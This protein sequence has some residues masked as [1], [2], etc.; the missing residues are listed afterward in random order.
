MRLYTPEGWF[1][2][3]SVVNEGYPFTFV[4]G[5]RATGKTFGALKKE[6]IDSEPGHRFMLIRR[7]Q[8]Q[9]DIINKPEFSPFKPV[10]SLLG[11]TTVTKTISKYNG[12]FYDGELQDDGT[13]VPIGEPLGFSAALSTF[14]NMRSFAADEIVRMIYDEFIPQPQERPIRDEANALYNAIESVN[15]NRELSGR[16]PVQLVGLA[17]ANSLGN[18]IFL[19]LKLV[20]QAEKMLNTGREWWTDDRRGILLIMLQH[21]AISTAKGETVL[22]KLKAG[23]EFARMALNNEFSAEERGIIGS[24]ALRELIPVVAVGEICIYRMKSGGYYV[25]AHKSG[26]PSEYGSGSRELDRFRRK[27]IWLWQAYMQRHVQ[28]EEYICEILFNRYFGF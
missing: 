10:D 2:Y 20:R 9:V 21:S 25:S 18:P 4:C 19:D 6:R 5:G 24:V 16:A 14:A 3:D 27:Y 26:S 22:Y 17:N 15:R 23:S 11:T 28:F 8:A 7:F 12:A 1:D 13:A